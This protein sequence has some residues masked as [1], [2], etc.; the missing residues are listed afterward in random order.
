MLA[1]LVADLAGSPRISVEVLWDSRLPGTPLTLPGGN[2]REHQERMAWRVVSGP[3]AAHAEL[4]ARAATC[5]AVWLIAPESDGLLADLARSVEQVGGRL[6]SPGEGAVRLCGDKLALAEWADRQ[7]VATIATRAYTTGESVE[8]ASFPLVVKPRD[9]AGSQS[10]WRVRDAAELARVSQELDPQDAWIRQPYLPGRAL[11]VAG[12]VT[13][14]GGVH[15]LP[16]AEQHLSSDGR[17]TYLGGSIPARDVDAARCLDRLGAVLATVPGLRGYIGC[18]LI[19][20]AD[21]GELVLC[22]INPRLTTS[23][24][25]YR[26]LFGPGLA[27]SLVLGEPPIFGDETLPTRTVSFQADG[28]VTMRPSNGN[29]S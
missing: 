1:G 14:G 19:E 5:D 6:V 9:G 26:K 13:E 18:D 22:E 28:E 10:T 7:G 23:Y 8:V 3:L 20:R 21:T 2:E 11:S 16:V 17:F 25:G 24:V 12:L 4:R 27:Q 29:P 15:W